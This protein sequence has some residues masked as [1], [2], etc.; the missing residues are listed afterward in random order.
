M[1][2]EE[3]NFMPL[4]G[5]RDIPELHKFQLISMTPASAYEQEHT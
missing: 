1:L 3:A 4:R 2:E 5:G